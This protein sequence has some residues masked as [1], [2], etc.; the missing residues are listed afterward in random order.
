[1]EVAVREE[2]AAD[3]PAVAAAAP[4]AATVLGPARVLMLQRL[5]GNRAVTRVLARQFTQYAEAERELDAQWH[6]SWPSIDKDL[7]DRLLGAK[8][9]ALTFYEAYE[10]GDVND[11]EF[12]S[13]GTDFAKTYGTLGM[14][15]TKDGPAKLGFGIPIAI[16][17][18]DDLE[19]AITSVHQVL[20]HLAYQRNPDSPSPPPIQTVAIFAHGVRRS[21]GLDPQ[22]ATGKNWFRADKIK[23]FVDAIKQHVAHD[24]RILLFACSAGGS[25]TGDGGM[26]APDGAG[27]AGSFAAELA[28]AL[29]GDAEV[30]AHDVA[31]HTESNPLARVF[32]AGS[33]TG[34]DLFNVFYDAKFI[35]AERDRARALKPKLADTPD[36][37]LDKQL[38]GMM[39]DHFVD[40]VSKDFARILTKDR[41]F[42]VGGYGGVGAAMFMDPAGTGKLLRDDFDT[43]WLPKALK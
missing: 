27:G 7:A 17:T 22:G 40:A 31:G 16:K 13:A 39:W 32:K 1:M 26:P 24:V 43:V 14:T 37:A 34:Q 25:E 23:T 18:R 8:S 19:Q 42:S 4:A 29:G 36:D 28:E 15:T 5:A 30:Y 6:V 2:Q 41:H 12:K 38:R 21:L 9:I 10:T 20:Y 33:K 3:E 11:A 35:A